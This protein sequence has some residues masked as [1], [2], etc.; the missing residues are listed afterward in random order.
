MLTIDTLDMLT[1][2]VVDTNAYSV[3]HLFPM[4]KSTKNGCVVG[5]ANDPEYI[6]KSNVHSVL[7]TG[8]WLAS[9]R[10]GN[11]YLGST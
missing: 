9:V 1:H 8:S 11:Q 10:R 5:N 3:C 4:Q 6:L 7:H 2:L